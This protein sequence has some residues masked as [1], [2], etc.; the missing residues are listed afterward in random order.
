MQCCQLHTLRQLVCTAATLL[1]HCELPTQWELAVELTHLCSLHSGIQK[2]TQEPPAMIVAEKLPP[3]QRWAT[4]QLNQCHKCDNH[5]SRGC[6]QRAT[7]T[8]PADHNASG[9]ATTL[10]IMSNASCYILGRLHSINVHHHISASCVGYGSCSA[11]VAHAVQWPSAWLPMV[12]SAT[13]HA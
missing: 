3:A 10:V 6:L 13:P 11:A 12:V 1:S 7:V 2:S 4:H 8:C 9:C 5:T